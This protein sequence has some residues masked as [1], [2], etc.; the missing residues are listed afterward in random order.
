MHFVI[1]PKVNRFGVNRLSDLLGTGRS[2]GSFGFVES[3]AGVLPGQF[4]V[5]EK[6]TYLALEIVHHILVLNRQDA[7]GEHLMPM[8]QH[9]LI[10]KKVLADFG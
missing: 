2:Y 3:D 7:V 9:A 10:L 1:T 4:A 5:L 8:I 6:S